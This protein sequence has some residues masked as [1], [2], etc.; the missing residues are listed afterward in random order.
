MFCYGRDIGRFDFHVDALA[1]VHGPYAR[2]YEQKLTDRIDS[3]ISR[4]ATD[5]QFRGRVGRIA[6]HGTQKFEGYIDGRVTMGVAFTA[7]VGA[8]STR[9]T[10][11]AGAPVGFGY[12]ILN[13]TRAQMG[14]LLTMAGRT[15]SDLALAVA[16]LSTFEP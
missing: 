1:G 15:P 2:R 10:G 5:D 9:I 6:W 16:I 12:G 11:P 14:G 3:V 8:A 7:A 13:F 4:L